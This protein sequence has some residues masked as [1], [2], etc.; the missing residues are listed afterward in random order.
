MRKWLIQ[1]R[2]KSKLSQSELSSLCNIT[3]QY[4]SYIEL[5]ERRPSP[6]TAQKIAE[7]LNFDWTLFFITQTKC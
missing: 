4:Y 7:V 5:G 3:Q 1:A 6:E 2:E